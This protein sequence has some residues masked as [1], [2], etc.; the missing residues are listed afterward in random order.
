MDNQCEVLDFEKALNVWERTAWEARGFVHMGS[1]RL[2]WISE[3]GHAELKGVLAY[4]QH[5][6]VHV[7]GRTNGIMNHEL[8]RR[9]HN[10]RR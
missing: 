3:L 6:F 1:V 7:Y 9:T 2:A 5:T 4:M 10:E 8:R